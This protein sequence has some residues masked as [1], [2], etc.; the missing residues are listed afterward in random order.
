MRYYYYTAWESKADR[1]ASAW[2]TPTIQG[3]V[4]AQNIDHAEKM[5]STRGFVRDTLT[6]YSRSAKRNFDHA[7]KDSLWV[8]VSF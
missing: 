4:L 6:Y 1:K 5:L 2:N 8:N 7:R 3:W